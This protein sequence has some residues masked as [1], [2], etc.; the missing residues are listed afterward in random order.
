MLR[1][2]APRLVV[3]HA[4][5]DRGALFI[6]AADVVVKGGAVR[7]TKEI[8]LYIDN[9][10]SV[11]ELSGVSFEKTG[12]AA[13]SVMAGTVGGIGAGN[14]FEEG[15]YIEVRGGEVE[16]NAKWQNAGAPYQLTQDVYIQGK[17]NVRGE[18]LDNDAGHLMVGAPTLNAAATPTAVGKQRRKRPSSRP[19]SRD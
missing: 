8:G 2:P 5:D 7:S 15:A 12:G 13:L 18:D 14:K 19:N 9:E 11:T 1:R 16:K 10:G 17:N 4:G 6:A 3:E